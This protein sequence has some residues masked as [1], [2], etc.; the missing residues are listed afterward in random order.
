MKNKIILSITLIVFLFI[1]TSCKASNE[2]IYQEEQTEVLNII[3]FKE[4]KFIFRNGLNIEDIQETMNEEDKLIDKRYPQ[5]TGLINKEVEKRINDDIV[6]LVNERLNEVE[7]SISSIHTDSKIQSIS[8]S[9]YVNYNCNNV[10]FIE[11]SSWITYNTG[12]MSESYYFTKFQGYD[13]N[14]GNHITL[15]DLFKQGVDYNKIIN[16]YIYMEIIRSNYD[17]PDSLFMNKPFQ[18]IQDNQSFSFDENRLM[19]TMDE[20]NEEFNNNGYPISIFISLKDIGDELAIFDRYFNEENNIFENSERIKKLMPNF[21]YY[22]ATYSIM[23]YE[24]YYNIHIEKGE[25]IGMEDIETKK[26]LDSMVS[27][28]LDVDGFKERAK[29]Y[30]ESNPSI[31][32]LYYGHIDHTVDVM[33]NSGGY[34]SMNVYSN[35]SENKIVE[36]YHK[37][38]NFDL[39]NNEIM[40]LKDLFVQDYD[41][42]TELIRIL[43]T[44]GNYSVPEGTFAEDSE[45]LIAENDFTFNQDGVLIIFYQPGVHVREYQMWIYYEDIE[46]ENLSIF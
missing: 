32:N 17:D 29:E 36:N 35:K 27:H 24:D 34:L 42:K 2:N 3:P 30:K 21:S 15:K 22:N 4:R 18:G 23:E 14:T 5:I 10:M 39:N 45:I 25:F 40:T 31:Y 12:A 1:V 46:Y 13:L 44:S 37:Y 38:I 43:R 6:N 28:N 7:N 11:Y 9:A 8:T 41:Y 20:K 19:I 33:I 26:L 16:D